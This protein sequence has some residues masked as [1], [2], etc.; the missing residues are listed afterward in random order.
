MAAFCDGGSSPVLHHSIFYDF[1]ELPLRPKSAKVPNPWVILLLCS[2][3]GGT[4]VNDD[5]PGPNIVKSNHISSPFCLD[6]RA[7]SC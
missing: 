3:T 1:K 7:V 5:T 4:D 2:P 6:F